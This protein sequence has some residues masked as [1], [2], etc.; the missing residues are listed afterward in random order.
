MSAAYH[1]AGHVVMAW[2][3]G[4][5]IGAVEVSS[6]GR[7]RTRLS[8]WHRS[9]SMFRDVNQSTVYRDVLFVLAGDCGEQLLL[10]FDDEWTVGLDTYLA[11]V[12]SQRFNLDLYRLKEEAGYMMVRQRDTIRTL[13]HLLYS[14]GKLDAYGLAL[15]HMAWLARGKNLSSSAHIT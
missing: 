2:L 7:G 14:R 9:T 11:Y 3:L 4:I 10:S 13:A 12:L 6:D 1:E 5:P 8:L 15:L